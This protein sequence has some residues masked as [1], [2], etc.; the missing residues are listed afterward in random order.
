MPS[1][2]RK[3]S[4]VLSILALFAALPATA[5]RDPSLAGTPP[6]SKPDAK[7]R[8]GQLL[9]QSAY[10]YR[11]TG[12]TTWTISRTGSNLGSYRIIV[13]AGTDY[14][15]LGVVV[16]EKRKMRMSQEL[17]FKLLR[18][19]DT[20]ADFVK[21]GLDADEDLFV[22]AELR[23]RNLDVEDFKASTESVA[24]V[25]DRVYGEIRTFLSAQ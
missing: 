13:A 2:I 8:I 18:L 20:A 22:R 10:S 9:Q 6:Q 24:S 11:S 4:S 3:G 19:N 17:L 1:H 14:L 12:D 16:A 7:A 5:R 25:S 21:I 23:V 15:I